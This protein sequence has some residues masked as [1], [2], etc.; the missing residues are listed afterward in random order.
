MDNGFNISQDNNFS[1]NFNHSK[2]PRRSGG[3]FVPFIAGI[4]GASLVLG[5]C[6]GVPSIKKKL[7]GETTINYLP[8][9]DTSSEN[10]TTDINVQ[11]LSTISDTTASVAQ[12]VLPSVVG[13]TIEYLLQ[14]HLDQE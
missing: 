8:S 7:I 10:K 12:K 9:Q 14:K 11:T 13:I 3:F 4:L 2:G 6:F 5:I 1:N